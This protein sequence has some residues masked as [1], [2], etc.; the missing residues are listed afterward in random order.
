M[1]GEIQNAIYYITCDYGLTATLTW[2]Y[3]SQDAANNWV[4]TDFE[5]T[6]NIK[7]ICY[8]HNKLKPFKICDMQ[9]LSA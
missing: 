4:N 5:L 6:Q 7:D 9:T 8:L 2:Y 3:F 1:T